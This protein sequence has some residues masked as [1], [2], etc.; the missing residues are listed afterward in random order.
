MKNGETDQHEQRYAARIGV[1]TGIVLAILCAAYHSYATLVNR[2]PA[3]AASPGTLPFSGPDWADENRCLD[4]HEQAEVF[5][6]TGH[7]RTLSRASSDD[8]IKILR[9]LKDSSIGKR[10]N[11][12]VDMDQKQVQAE[13]TIDSFRSQTRLDWCF[14]SGTH[15]RTW[16]SVMPD[17]L[18]AHDL[19]EFRWTWYHGISEF[20]VTP[21]QP[22]EHGAGASASLGLLFDGPRAWRCFSC[23][24]SSLPPIDRPFEGEDL[25][26]GVTCQRCHGP[27]GEHVRSEG[28]FH[29]PVWRIPEDRDKAVAQCAVCHRSPEE[30]DEQ[31]IWPGNPDITRFQPV[32]LTRSACYINSSMTCTTC[33]DP[34]VP[35][36]RPESTSIRQCVQCHDPQHDDHVLCGAD[37]SDN[38]LECHMPAV[39][40][41]PG[42][43]F[44]DHWIRVLAKAEQN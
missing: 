23:H 31:T 40:S 2:S 18:G 4:C 33:H 1:V 13:R 20:G 17:A 42:L 25:H 27:R 37:M 12:T 38:C 36:T 26:P 28:E 32:G 44:T 22:D 39:P 6:Q 14:G 10:E 8:S 3:V 5:D 29:D 21:G 41:G 30:Q 11:V 35:M 16:V 24:S 34:H 15:A 7:A 19:L 9:A 43:A